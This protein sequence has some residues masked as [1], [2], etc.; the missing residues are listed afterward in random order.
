M[1]DIFGDLRNWGRV[2]KQ[3]EQ[4]RVAGR[5]DEHQEGLTRI[6][7]YPY[8]WQL[9]RAALRAVP[10]LKMPSKDLLN[11]LL[12][13][14]NDEDSALETRLL[15]CDAVR[16]SIRRQREQGEPDRFEALAADWAARFLSTPQPP[17]LRDA[18]EAWLALVQEAAY[19][20]R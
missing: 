2:L 11:V 3:L 1:S 17:V 13:I 6:L 5:L 7:R 19:A 18:V 10:D 4:L 12:G 16:H 8:N 9:R 20:A 14:V 15:A